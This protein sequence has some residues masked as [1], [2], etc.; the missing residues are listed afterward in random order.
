MD[1]NTFL[2]NIEKNI[3]DILKDYLFNNFQKQLIA[4]KLK[5]PFKKTYKEDYLW[6]KVL[7]ISN[8][9][10]I[11]ISESRN[12][13]LTTEAMKIS[14]QIYENL[15]EVSEEY[16]RK[17]CL[18]LSALCYDLAGYSANALCM[19][20]SLKRERYS[21]DTTN[22]EINIVA[23][24]YILSHVQQ[25]LLKNIFKARNDIKDND[26]SDEGLKLFNEALASWYR[27]IL[28]GEETG[29][30]DK[31]QK[32]YSYY[33]NTF[34]LPIAHVLLLLK[35]RLKK[36]TERSIWKNLNYDTDIISNPIWNKY[37][38]LLTYDL[39][40]ESGIKDIE[41]RIS[42]FELWTSQ[43]RAIEKGLITEEKNFVIQMPT[44]TGKTFIAEISI[45]N[46]LIKN[47]G[48]KCIYIA[49]FRALTSEKEIE[50][51]KNLSKLGFSI[52]A[53]SGSYEIDDFQ[54]ISLRESDV[55]IATPEKI[56]LLLRTNPEYFIDVSLMVVDEGHIVGYISPRS[57]LL[58]FLIIRLKIKIDSLRI[59]FIS[60]VMPPANA[61]QYSLWLSGQKEN[62]VRSLLHKD[63]L[64]N[65]EW[66]P[67]RKLIGKFTWTGQS[68]RIDFVNTYTENEENKVRQGAFIP[69]IINVKQYGE[70]NYKKDRFPLS[71]RGKFSIQVTPD[72]PT[73][74]K[75]KYNKAQTAAMLGYK[76][77]DSGSTLIFCAKPDS[78]KS[79]GEAFIRYFNLENPENI[80]SDF[81]ED[82]NKQSYF[83]S[84]IWYGD[85]SYIT[86]CLKRG[87]GIHFGDMPEQVRNAV[88]E[89]FRNRKL[90]ILI[91][92]NTIG[93]GINFPI[94]NLIFHSTVISEV[95]KILN[96]DFWNI[97]GRAGRA[98]H[99]T[100]GQIIF[101][102]NSYSD[103]E[104]FSEYIDKNNLNPA[105]SLFFNVLNA[106]IRLINPIS[107]E[108]YENYLKILSE[109]YLFDFLTE[110]TVDE[111]NVVEK[112]VNNSLFKVQI[113]EKQLDIT[114]LKDS[115]I[116]I[117]K[118]LREEITPNQAQ[119][120]GKTGLSLKSNRVISEFIEEQKDRLQTVIETDDYLT[121]LL[122][123]FELF[124]TGKIS[125]I[126]I[127][128]L[129]QFNPSQFL[130]ITSS[131]ISGA[132]ID[133]LRSGWQEIDD[134]INKFFVLL[135]QGFYYRYPWGISSFLTVM[136]SHL[137]L[138][139][140]NLPT[141][142]KNLTS[143]IKFGLNNPNSCLARS[144]GIKSRIISKLLGE[145]F[146][147]STPKEFITYLSMLD[148]EDLDEDWSS[149][150]K[151]NILDVA[152]RL[153]P[154]KTESVGEMIFFVK[155]I[156]YAEVRKNN[157]LLVNIH[158]ELNLKREYDNSY[159]PYAI[160]I[161]KNEAEIGYLPREVSRKIAVEMDI[162]KKQ[163][164][165][166]VINTEVLIFY[167]NIVCSIIET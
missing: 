17:Y 164:K 2:D 4:E 11:L 88:E 90:M 1:K 93:Q 159:D 55:L 111:D 41:K 99:E 9:S 32:T 155:G 163:F 105:Y 118:H 22:E 45:L 59:L 31:I 113:T 127:D 103:N 147:G 132:S 38:K 145:N 115:F 5:A 19:L 158:D 134:D 107:D 39:Y 140:K 10:C 24:N 58:E 143:Y 141:N 49:P 40:D 71:E 130:E 72:E 136:A 150:D 37:I 83:Y 47:P 8:N 20:K 148:K 165:A 162:E 146:N 97:I 119:L 46:H 64:P 106:K 42:R 161:F 26:E 34:N 76:F 89:D 60:A 137:G 79:I 112:I 28:D 51:A 86:K 33:L 53:L 82:I 68:G 63:S 57:S 123:I 167:N 78:T 154:K 29:Y 117:I 135:S 48:K 75:D 100:E 65:E 43:L 152:V 84:R 128:K 61:D 142:I 77:S 95:N 16:D 166:L 108:V 70:K 98:G 87:I 153:S 62:V 54:D 92:T 114:I 131:W 139:L 27:N 156:E 91:S 50:L 18:I 125:E 56:D 35:T 74:E 73:E 149:Y 116:K 96:R 3:L 122:I 6:N 151:K 36:Y 110:E 80:R 21:F 15:S 144:V 25:I 129:S 124:D 30:I 14:A 133:E 104:S 101:L 23:D 109:P 120:Y 138:E 69:S 67:T 12:E 85:D 7:Y 160:K 52:S 94:K 102:I 44:S 126:M 121:L 13:K 81:S 66:E 157:S